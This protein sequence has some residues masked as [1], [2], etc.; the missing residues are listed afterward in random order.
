MVTSDGTCRPRRRAG[1]S[2]TFVA[3]CCS[4]CP[5]IPCVWKSREHR[6]LSS[7]TSLPIRVRRRAVLN[8]REPVRS[9]TRA[10]LAC[11]RGRWRGSVPTG[12]RRRCSLS[13]RSTTARVYHPM[14]SGSR[15]GSTAARGRSSTCTTVSVTCRP[16]SPTR[17]RRVR[18]RCGPWMEDICCSERTARLVASGGYARM[19]RRHRFVCSTRVW[20]TSARTRCRQMDGTSS[21]LTAARCGP[22]RST[23]RMSI[24]RN[25]GHRSRSF[26]RRPTRPNRDFLQTVAGWRTRRMRPARMRSMCARSAGPRLAPAASGK[27]RAA[28][29]TIRYG[30]VLDGNCFST[31]VTA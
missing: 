13:R 11:F 29:A 21:T 2:S 24:V 8:S 28:G 3:G 30:L 5:L 16:A 1:I 23:C 27:Y 26:T 25:P 20:V 6:R 10:V 14:D 9:S 12:R 19:R 31:Q 22:S 17:D 15:S 4:L 18:T 7:R